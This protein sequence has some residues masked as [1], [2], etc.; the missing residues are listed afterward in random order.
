MEAPKINS[1]VTR[2]TL[3]LYSHES[4]TVSTQDL[5]SQ[6]K[7]KYY[8]SSHAVEFSKIYSNKGHSEDS[9]FNQWW[10]YVDSISIDIQKHYNPSL[11][12]FEFCNSPRFEHLKPLVDE[13]M[14]AVHEHFEQR[15][16]YEL[17]SDI[18]NESAKFFLFLVPLFATHKPKVYIDSTNGCVNVDLPTRDNGI[19]STQISSNGQV[20]Y[21]LAARNRKIFKISGTAKFKDTKDLIKFNKVL[22]ML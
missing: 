10:I 19:L 5:P 7:S 17:I 11:E 8:L 9:H 4:K 6:Q 13:F 15:K 3:T 1:L 14:S 22:Q 2:K 18:S 20:H 21:S 16:D 12:V